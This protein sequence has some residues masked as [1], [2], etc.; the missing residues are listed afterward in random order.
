MLLVACAFTAALSGCGSSEEAAQERPPAPPQQHP[1]PL[2]ARKL[3]FETRTDTVTAVHGADRR[4]AV[5]PAR[6]VQIR[7]MVQIGAFQDPHRASEVQAEARRR[8]K[9][10]VLNDFHAARGLYQIRLGFFVSRESAHEFRQRMMK[11]YPADYRD[12]WVVQLK[13]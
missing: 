9:M 7:Y 5:T 4:P 3:E 8:Y 10:P 12:S 11:E 13:R 6:E 1:V 2:P